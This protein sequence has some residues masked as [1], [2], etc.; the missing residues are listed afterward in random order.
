MALPANLLTTLLDDVL[1][2]WFEITAP[3]DL[4]TAT[5]TIGCWIGDL[6]DCR[7]SVKRP[8]LPAKNLA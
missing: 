3:L 7:Y 1:K 2:T 8:I 5:L 6:F 4:L